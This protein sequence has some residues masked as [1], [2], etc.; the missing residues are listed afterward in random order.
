[1]TQLWNLFDFPQGSRVALVGAGGKTTLLY[2]FSKEAGKETSALLTTTTRILTPPSHVVDTL[3]LGR[4]G[5]PLP[6]TFVNPG[7]TAM[8]RFHPQTGK[9]HS[10]PLS[11]LEEVL[12]AFP[13][14]FVEADG[15]K[16][17][18]LKGWSK[19][20]PVIPDFVTHTVGITNLAYLG[21]PASSSFIHRLDQFSHLTGCQKGE[22]LT[23]EH[24]ERL[25]TGTRG[26]FHRA[27]GKQILFFNHC[28]Q[29]EELDTVK[30]FIRTRPP[31]FFTNLS[32][33]IGGS[34]QKE[35]G[36]ILWEEPE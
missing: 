9:L 36:E 2:L 19:H 31:E 24:M 14:V 25:I 5:Q 23:M 33:I 4:K 30:E 32:Q 22:P 7:V 26:L 12:P 28:E 16:R 29:L 10:L 11:Q 18:P 15:S 35:R 1:M 34:G 6:D 8:G 21:T 27:R 20:E 13:Y 17:K 3:W